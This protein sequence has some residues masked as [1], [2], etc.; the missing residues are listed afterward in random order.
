[1]LFEIIA[2][3]ENE[4]SQAAP[5]AAGTV[6]P[7]A[8]VG[9]QLVI[10]AFM[11]AAL[12]FVLIRPQRKKEKETRDMIA[13]VNVGDKIV[14]IGGIAGKITKIKDEYVFIESGSVGNPNEKSFL[15]IE[16][17]AIKTVEKKQQA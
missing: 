10:L 3:A 17:S 7:A 15:K 12:Y 13:A 8:S 11:F 4:V 5:E 9:V 6:S 16:R 2:F 14:T 1:M